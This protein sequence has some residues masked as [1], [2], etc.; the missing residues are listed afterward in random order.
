MWQIVSG[1]YAYCRAFLQLIKC[2]Y[3]VVIL[4]LFRYEKFDQS[5][6]VIQ[7]CSL[8]FLIT[9]KQ[10]PKYRKFVYKIRPYTSSC[11]TNLAGFFLHKLQKE[12]KATLTYF[13]QTLQFERKRAHTA[14]QATVQLLDN[15]I[16]SSW[17]MK[18][19]CI[20]LLCGKDLI[21]GKNLF[22]A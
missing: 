1:L 15:K 17:E 5:V 2:F 16:I 6:F 14:K 7:I 3:S 13:M 12:R 20:S 4:A 19:A 21:L 18:Y 9:D 22:K 10:K 11:G 8:I